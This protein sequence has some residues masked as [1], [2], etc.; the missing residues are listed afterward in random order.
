[1]KKNNIKN[2]LIEAKAF[3]KDS[4]NTASLDAE[5]LLS[6]LLNKPREYLF[7]HSEENLSDAFCEKW[8]QWLSKRKQGIPIA[9]LLGQKEFWGL[10]LHV[11]EHT[12]IPR[13]ETELLVELILNDREKGEACLTCLDLGT[14]SGAIA[15]ALAKEKPNWNIVAVDIS[16]QALNTAKNNAKKQGLDSIVFIESDWFSN[17]DLNE[18][19]GKFHIIVSNPP[20][21]DHLDPHL[22]TEEIRYEP[23][24]ALIANKSGLGDIEK[25]IK[26]APFYL[27]PKGY[28]FIEH[29]SN[30]GEA[31]RSLFISQG[32][33]E[34][35]SVCDLAG[36]ERVSYAQIRQN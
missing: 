32:Y 23:R 13:P 8:N 16:P 6:Y 12:L 20:Y 14:G 31:V 29:G 35:A 11:N 18:W 15:L 27:K 1:M 24:Q 25:I 2:L 26:Q 17:L 10:M 4:S 28:L 5:L 3:L 9:Y 19:A 21:L 7:S 34:V 36:L 33:H 22:L 30:Q